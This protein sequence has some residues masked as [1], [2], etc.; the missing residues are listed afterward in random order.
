MASDAFEIR[1]SGDFPDTGQREM[2]PRNG[3]RD[4]GQIGVRPIQPNR[5]CFEEL[6]GTSGPRMAEDSGRVAK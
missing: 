6:P 4:F 1:L 3:R 5:R 2:G